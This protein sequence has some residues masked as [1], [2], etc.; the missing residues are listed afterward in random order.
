MLASTATEGTSLLRSY[1]SPA[2]EEKNSG[3][4]TPTLAHQAITALVH[5]GCIRMI[6]TTSFGSLPETAFEAEA[7]VSDSF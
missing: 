2:E 3:R 7:V 5:F 1:L 6:I 4:E